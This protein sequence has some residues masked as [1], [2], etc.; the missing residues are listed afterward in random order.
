MGDTN[1]RVLNTY[2][3][4]AD[5]YIER[6]PQSVE[7]SLGQW[8]DAVFAGIPQDAYILEIG[9]AGGRDAK[10]LEEELGFTNVHR[11]DAAIGFVERLRNQGYEANQLNILTDEIEPE[12]A[13]VILANAVLL[14]FDPSELG[15]ALKN[16]CQG[17]N[18]GGEFYFTVAKRAPGQEREGWSS[19]KVGEER[20]FFRPDEEELLGYLFEAGFSVEDTVILVDADENRDRQWYNVATRRVE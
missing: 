11:T 4:T 9:S 2:N 12:S 18:V 7:G 14:H 13:D 6:S 10:Y 5:K 1:K 19:E 20:F 16:I 15:Q 8:I 17:L 3:L